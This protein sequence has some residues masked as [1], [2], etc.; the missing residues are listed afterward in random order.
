MLINKFL[1]LLKKAPE[2][3]LEKIMKEMLNLFGKKVL[4]E[5]YSL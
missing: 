3:D 1:V 5:I 4:N 2:K